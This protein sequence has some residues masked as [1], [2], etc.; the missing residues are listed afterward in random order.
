MMW[1]KNPPSNSVYIIAGIILIGLMLVAITGEYM[2]SRFKERKP[3]QTP[4]SEAW[5]ELP[6]PLLDSQT[7]VEEALS[8]RRSVREYRDAP[9]TL[10]EV[11]QLLW[12]AQGITS[13]EGM[14]TAP[15]AGALYP[16]E[17]YL[18]A[19]NVDGLAAGVYHYHPHEH[20]L[21]KVIEGDRR[22]ALSEAALGQEAVQDGAV[23]IVIAG[24]FERTTRKYGERGI[25]Y[26]HMEVG[27]VA[28]NIYLQAES[29]GL[30]TVF[31]G[32]FYDDQVKSVVGLSHDEQPLCL[33][34]VGR[35]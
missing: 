1:K 6:S 22:A 23:V 35:K 25:Q 27:S 26:V 11:A 3:L 12:S 4:S 9:L 28:Q 31:I 17:V 14:R 16:L 34:P 32:A 13:P 24:V 2:F 8:K 30:G 15:S 29:L 19:G 18:L 33:M 7:S 20:A 10:N 21:S 5:I